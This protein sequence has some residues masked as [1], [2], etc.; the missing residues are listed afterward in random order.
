MLIIHM[1]A[2]IWVYNT[3]YRMNELYELTFELYELKLEYLSYRTL[4]RTSTMIRTIVSKLTYIH[5]HI[6]CMSVDL[7][8]CDWSN[9]VS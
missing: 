5:T 3:I 8:N 7:Y 1:Y 9:V 2:Y 6:T 4:D